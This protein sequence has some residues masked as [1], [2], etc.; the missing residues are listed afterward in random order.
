MDK[1]KLLIEFIVFFVTYM[2]WRVIMTKKAKYHLNIIQLNE[3]NNDKYRDWIKNN[4]S[5][6]YSPFDEK[7]DSKTPLVMTDRAN[8]LLAT[9]MN[10]YRALVIVVLLA[11]LCF[12]NYRITIYA[13]I[14]FLIIA[15]FIQPQ[16]MLL[17]N[18]INLPKEKKINMGFYTSAQDKIKRLK[19]ES[20]LKVIGITGSFGKTS[21]KFFTS[22][23]LDEKFRVQNTP[24]SYKSPLN[25]PA[26]Y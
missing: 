2:V 1:T 23:M 10:I 3:Y 5:K 26:H 24:S 21:V 18:S 25:C 20:G 13:G 22:T 17:A 9:Y 14:I 12:T 11:I 6:A 15:L 16:V 7:T 19:A 8:R 4:F